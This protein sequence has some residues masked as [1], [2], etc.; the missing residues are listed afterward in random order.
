MAAINF[1]KKI[2]FTRP[3]SNRK[4]PQGEYFIT[5]HFESDRGRIINSAAIR[6]LQQKT[7]VFPLERNAAVRS[8]LTHSL[9]V[10]QTGR[11]ISKE[12][13]Q[14]LKMQGGLAK[15]GLDDME[16]AFESLVEMACLLHDVG[17]PPFGHFGEA[18][19]ND[20]FEDNLAAELVDPLVAGVESEEQRQSFDQMNAM[21]RQDLCHFEGNAQAIRMVHTLLQLNLSYSQVACILKYTAPAWWQGE[22]PAEF[23][24]LMKK[25][26]FY[27]SE[28]EYISDLRAA[29]HLK[30]HH[31]FPLTYIMEAAD[32]ISYCIADLD[33]A[34]E[35][36]IFNVDSLYEFLSKAWGPINNNDAFSRTVGEA[37]REAGSKKRRS[38]SDQFFMSLRVNVQN[39]L[40]TYAVKRFIDNLPAIF[41]GNFNH[42][43]LE[44]GG[45]EGRLLQIFKTVA[46]QQV[47]NHSE[48][49]QLELQG[50]R[51][52]KGLL[53]IYQPL[54]MLNYEDFTTL[55]NEDFLRNHPIETRLFHKLS[56]KHRKAYLYKM[57]TLVVEH[58]YERLLWERY[59]RFRLIQDYI[60]GMTDLYAWD[61]YRR[62]MAVE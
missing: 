36:A 51:V 62:L 52:I 39:V 19:I 13:L 24:V 18:A 54:M 34:V 6:R 2:S 56:G 23:S 10:Q 35:K 37:W 61:E 14:T 32:D 16:G 22:K 40:V 58:K 1:R 33:D 7:Q 12:I 45:E 55:I 27:L 17:N 15:Y 49:E 46:R 50:Y 47:F 28:R 43:L 60:S 29:T 8:R 42:A 57:R 20:W 4:D 25:P 9:E 48:V 5:R 41:D 30:E 21:I 26:G 44:D 11:Y 3:Y 53:E 59:Y 38:R 31:R